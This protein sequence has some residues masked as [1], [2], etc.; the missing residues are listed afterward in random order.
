M[1]SSRLPLGSVSKVVQLHAGAWFPS[2]T[3]AEISRP[4]S[5][6]KVSTRSAFALPVRIANALP[7][8]RIDAPSA[9]K[10]APPDPIQPLGVA[11][12]AVALSRVSNRYRRSSALM[13]SPS[14]SIGARGIR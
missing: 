7:P 2:A 4:A 3:N 1:V 5:R 9:S 13:P 8:G 12:L 11:S 10:L 6:V 14:A